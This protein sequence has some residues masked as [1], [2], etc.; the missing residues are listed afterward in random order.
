MAELL[1]L[2]H[3]DGLGMKVEQCVV[4][5]CKRLVDIGILMCYVL[6]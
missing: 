6:W 1:C 5:C 4:F 2:G 3:D